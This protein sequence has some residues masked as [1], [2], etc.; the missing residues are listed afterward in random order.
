MNRFSSIL[1][2]SVLEISSR[3]VIYL[4]L[5]V[6]LVAAFFLAV[7]PS[8][9][10]EGEDIFESG[11]ISPDMIGM[12][13]VYFYS[14]YWGF[15]I[16]LM[17]FGSAW[18][19]PSYLGRGRIELTLSKPVR[20]MSLLGM[21]FV[22]VFLVKAVLLSLSTVVIWVVLSI[23]LGSFSL[24]F[25]PGLAMAWLVFL[26]VYAIV[27]SIG[28]VSRSGALAIMGYLVI[29]IAAKLLAGRE[30]VYQFLGK[31]WQIILDT[32]Y[33]IVPKMGQMEDSY[34]TLMAGEGFADFYPVW[35]SLLFAAVVVMGAL[36]VFN[37]RDW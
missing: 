2:D 27:F 9:T 36:L 23:R 24:N 14:G 20:R 25:V 22:S 15:F 29:S 6:T 1:A 16:L 5:A 3:W 8:F 4:Y 21:K 10:I 13:V 19:V 7:L 37:R 26:V 35:S 30:L 32:I 18:L 12:F 33:H 34:G 31:S 11:M 17:I 28:V